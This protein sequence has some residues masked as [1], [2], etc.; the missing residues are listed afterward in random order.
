MSIS[1]IGYSDMKSALK[2][3][4]I[5]LF[6]ERRDIF[7]DIF[8]EIIEEVGLVEKADPI[9]ESLVDDEFEQNVAT[10]I[11]AFHTLHPALLEQYPGEFVAI[12]KQQLIDH[13][14][15][16]LALYQRIHE[17]YPEQFVLMRRVEEEPERELQ[18]RSTRFFI[19]PS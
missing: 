6:Q 13:D 12:H 2:D 4:L 5:E 7:H 16:K 19:Q 9:T 1:A 15:D 3:A 10:E 18:L 17:T 14:I 11:D 8:R